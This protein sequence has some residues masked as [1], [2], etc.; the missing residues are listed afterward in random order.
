MF[1]GNGNMKVGSLEEE[2]RAEGLKPNK[3]LDE[4]ERNIKLMEAGSTPVS[5]SGLPEGATEDRTLHERG[6]KLTEDG[7]PDSDSDTEVSD[8]DLEEMDE[9]ELATF[10]E[11]ASREQLV[12]KAAKMVRR[13]TTRSERRKAHRGPEYRQQL[14]KQ[15]RAKRRGKA[16]R[17]RMTRLKIRRAGGYKA[18]AKKRA[19]AGPHRMLR[20]DTDVVDNLREELEALEHQTPET[21]GVNPYE[22]AAIQAGALCLEMADIFEALGDEGA[23]EALMRVHEFAWDLSEE[24]EKSLTEDQDDIPEEMETKLQTVLE[25]TTK[26]LAA[27]EKL[28]SPSIWEAMEQAEAA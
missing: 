21:S 23:S 4:I 25:A 13:T 6:K 22:V 16:K 20:F 9:A 19:K 7:N 26:V 18:V 8:K 12:E 3:M 27:W 14:R 10:M 1:P 17:N 15:K 5:T 2:L 11:H 24:M 28:G